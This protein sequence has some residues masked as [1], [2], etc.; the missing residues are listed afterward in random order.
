MR[1]WIL[2]VVILFTAYFAF[3]RMQH[4]QL[5][6]NSVMDR[7]IHPT[8]TRLRYSIGQVDP[9]FSLS[10]QQVQYVA[11]QAANIW[12]VGTGQSFFV[13]DPNAQLTINLIYDDRQAESSARSQ[14]MR[15]LE[16]TRQYTDAEH[17]KV[18]QL[19]QELLQAKRELDI[20]QI[21]YEQRL[22][23]YNQ[24]VNALNQ[25]QQRYSDN[26][27]QQIQQQK[28]QLQQQ[29]VELQ[30]NTDI[31]NRKVEHL[32]QNVNQANSINHQFN[33]SVDQFNQRFQPR[34]FDKGVFN[35]REIN[36]YE[37]QSEN[38][39]RITLAHELGHALGLKHNDDPKALMY[40]VMKEQNLYQ[41]QLTNADLA[42]LNSRK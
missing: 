29:Q 24:M 21:N 31:F 5:N 1:F 23:Q 37:F 8:D 34:Q 36:V 30:T 20:Q 35:G 17:F 28:Q 6:H 16:N 27:M 39:L 4:P 18:Q 15:I 13:Y 22:N 25:S 10:K 41:F 40:P 12:D 11:Q 2:V 26:V 33:Q 42:M 9:R 32:N 3:Q 38:D 7:I 14:E 19:E